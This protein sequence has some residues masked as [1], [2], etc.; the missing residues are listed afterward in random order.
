MSTPPPPPGQPENPEY[1]G[2]PA[3]ANPYAQAGHEQPTQPGYGQTPYGQPGYGQAPY[4]QPGYGQ[5]M[6]DT[7]PAPSR[8]AAGLLGI[9]LGGLGVH[10]FYLGYTGLGIVQIIL[11]IFT[12][13]LAAWWGVIEGIMI[14]ARAQ[15][16]LTDAHGRP[17][18]E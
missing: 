4:G 10:R 12:F 16:F 15:S 5:P 13:G 17:L 7:N 6:Y 1:N 3:Q 18:R 14:L 11:T 2:P 8:I 9:F